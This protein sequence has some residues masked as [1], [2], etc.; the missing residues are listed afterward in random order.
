MSWRDGAEYS[1]NSGSA[2]TVR[3]C[4]G[5]Q[6]TY[7]LCMIGRHQLLSCNK[8]ELV[9]LPKCAKRNDLRFVVYAIHE[10]PPGE[11]LVS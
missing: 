8:F 4:I 1:K 5:R 2:E 9:E 7:S 10:C 6:L 3:A 11:G